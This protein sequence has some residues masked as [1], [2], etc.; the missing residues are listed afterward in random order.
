MVFTLGAFHLMGA[1][2]D[3]DMQAVYESN[4]S[5]F[6]KDDADKAA[7]ESKY[8]GLGLKVSFEGGYPTMRCRCLETAVGTDGETYRANKVLKSPSYIPPVFQ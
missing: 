6:I 4:M 3:A 8:T 1:D 5:K 7:A 2:A